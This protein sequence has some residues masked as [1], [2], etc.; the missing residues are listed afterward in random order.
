MPSRTVRTIGCMIFLSGLLVFEG[1]T[2]HPYAALFPMVKNSSSLPRKGSF[3]DRSLMPLPAHS[4]SADHLVVPCNAQ[5]R[6]PRSSLHSARGTAA[7][8]ACPCAR[9]VGGT[10]CRTWCPDHAVDI[11]CWPEIP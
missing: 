1:T 8:S 11:G 3:P 9:S 6:Y 4:T 5:F 7:G 10:T 2:S